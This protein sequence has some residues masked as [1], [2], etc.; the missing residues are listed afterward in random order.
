[1][2]VT[3]EQCRRGVG[4]ALWEHS[5]TSLE[6]TGYSEVTLWVLELNYPARQFYEKIGFTLDREIQTTV[7]RGSK[8]FNVVR[9]RYMLQAVYRKH[10]VP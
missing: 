5:R 1:M 3:P 4:N 10:E 8:T 6:K 9:Y 2:Y 7:E